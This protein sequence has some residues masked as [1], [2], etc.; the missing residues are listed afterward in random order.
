MA[1]AL[2]GDFDAVLQVSAGTLRRLVANMHQNASGNPANPSIPH[3]AYLRLDDEVAGHRGS[4]A[5][6]IG[7][8]HLHLIGGAT[9]RIQ[10]EVGIRARY[11]ADP[12]SLPLADIIHGA[13]WA[14]YRLHDIDPR[15][16]AWQRAGGDYFWF[17]VVKDSVRFEGTV[18][19]E[20]SSL[21]LSHL[22]NE[23]LI[24]AHLTKHLA[25]IL[26]EQFEPAPQLVNKRFQRISSIRKGDGPADAAIAIPYG[27]TTETP[28]GNLASVGDI[29]LQGQDFGLA[30][31]SDFIMSKV[32][33]M[34][35]PL[36]G[37]QV[38]LHHEIDA[39]VGGGLSIDY[40]ARVDVADADW[41]GPA[42][43]PF[44]SAPG[45]FFRVR[46]TGVGWASRLYRSGVFMLESISASD[47]RIN[48]TI[49]Q[50]IRLTFDPGTEFFQVNAFGNPVVDVT[51]GP[52]AG[53]VV[54][55]AR[56]E[57]QKGAQSQLAGPLADAQT[58]LS[59]ISASKSRGALVQALKGL[60]SGASAHFADAVFR[61][62]GVVLCGPVSLTHR[63]RPQVSFER[64]AAGDGFDAIE[65]WIPGGRIDKFEWTWR[66]FTTPVEPSP[67]PPGAAAEVETFMLRRPQQARS[68]F[69]LSLFLEK[70]LPGLDGQGKVCLAVSG[71]QIDPFSG[72]L[73]PV[74][75]V[76]E[77]QQFGFEFNLP[78]EVGPLVRLWDPMRAARRR[79]PEVGIVRVGAPKAQAASN[80]LVLYF[81]ERWDD[82][83]IE[84]LTRGV[85]ACR[86][87]GT[88]LLFVLLFRE[89]AVADGDRELQAHMQALRARL[90]APMLAT[91]D[92]R[93]GWSSTLALPSQGQSPAWRLLNPSG[94][95]TWA[96]DGRADADLL[97]ATLDHRLVASAPPAF[98]TIRTE[99]SLG[100]RLP[101]ELARP[102]CPPLPVGQAGA[103]DAK[104]I[105]VYKGSDSAR[106]VL[107]RLRETYSAPGDDERPF[108]AVVV[109]GAD[110]REVD[111]L[112]DEL[113]LDVPFFPDPGG[114]LTQRAG[115]RLSPTTLTLD[116]SGTVTGLEMG[117]GD[118]HRETDAAAKGE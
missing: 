104:V 43:V 69:G 34:V 92:V 102:D 45:G 47:L 94:V 93:G 5:A 9:D 32:R 18:L 86:S 30:V 98:A 64:T 8:P 21:I 27:L 78:Y 24:K 3:V 22:L 103:G 88:G 95:V 85:E 6:Q 4:I 41:L 54:A 72:A 105:F 70:P 56:S 23:P 38:D 106:Q 12:G 115:V 36:V 97:A 101:I 109:E 108:V 73:V 15:C 112:R 19:N 114:V 58:Q 16:L 33:P 118:T 37:W 60:D 65:S 39:G 99:I 91:E 90:P 96:H 62:D 46:L 83:A 25:S 50:F 74:R 59:A 113:Q 66:W 89:G 29:F 117:V 107:E 51:G 68:K 2:T 26:A 84:T 87:R 42:S 82:E 31:S 110:A 116:G 53:Y 75:G 20:S 71:A 52:K 7:A 81:D 76:F 13:V 17:R 77:C 1:N 28:P 79:N 63:Y 48:F 44:L 67:G 80:T 10:I 57:I 35:A 40:H 55:A 49:E 11:R 111:A 14:E 61:P 100:A